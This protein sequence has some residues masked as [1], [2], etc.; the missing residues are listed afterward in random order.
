MIQQTWKDVVAVTNR[1]LSARSYYEQIER[2]CMMRPRAVLIREKDLPADA[3][4]A[5]AWKA[6]EICRKYQI[7]CIYHSYLQTAYSAGVNRIHLPMTLLRKYANSPVLKEFKSIGTSVHSV[8]EAQEAQS[9]G[10]T[11]LIAG[12]IYP[13]ECKKGLEGRGTGFLSGVCGSVS[14][15]VYAIGGIHTDCQVEEVLK[16]KAAGACIMSEAMII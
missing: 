1:K 12:H 7:P 2:I 11:V 13:T 3:Y 16:N 8:A 4:A 10:A 15:P 14:I 5:L 6:V 9:M